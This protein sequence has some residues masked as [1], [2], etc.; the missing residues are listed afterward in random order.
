[1]DTKIRTIIDDSEFRYVSA[2]DFIISSNRTPMN[3]RLV[4][5]IICHCD[6]MHRQIKELKQELDHGRQNS[7]KNDDKRQ[8]Q[9]N[10]I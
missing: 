6:E 7:E 2:W 3:P 9:F 4:N 5:E 10:T 1:M 8:M